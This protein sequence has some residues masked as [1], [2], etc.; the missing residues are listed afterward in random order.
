MAEMKHIPQVVDLGRSEI[1]TLLS[2]IRYGHLAMS[3]DDKPYVVPIHFAYGKAGV[4]FYTTEGLK[5]E[6]IEANPEVCLQAE[7][8]QEA[9]NWQSVIIKGTA[10]RLESED[11]IEAGVKALKDVNPRLVPAWSVRWMDGWVRSNVE[12]VYRITVLEMTGRRAFLNTPIH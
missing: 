4:Y 12:A 9:T 5:T 10:K 7:H 1:E 11:Q 6:I 2:S 8:I 3:R